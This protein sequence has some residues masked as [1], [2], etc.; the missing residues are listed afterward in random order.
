MKFNPLARWSSQQVWAFLE[1][2]GV[3]T[4]PL[5]QEGSAPSAVRLVHALFD[6]TSTS[7]KGAGGGKMPC[8]RNAVCTYERARPQSD[9]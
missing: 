8:P 7:G 4:N 3:P 5:H 1:E 2:E 6:P 9:E